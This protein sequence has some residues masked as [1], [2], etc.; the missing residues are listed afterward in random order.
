MVPKQRFADIIMCHPKKNSV[1]I[2]VGCRDHFILNMSF[3]Q[4]SSS[5][6]NFGPGVEDFTDLENN[7]DVGKKELGHLI[8]DSLS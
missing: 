3:F 8:D 7:I 5:S 6:W 1:R 4:S 2:K